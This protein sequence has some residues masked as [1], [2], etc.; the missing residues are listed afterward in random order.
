MDLL[1]VN[2]LMKS[3]EVND[4]IPI[5]MKAEELKDLDCRASHFIRQ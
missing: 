3:I 1:Y 4:V 5:E 2:K